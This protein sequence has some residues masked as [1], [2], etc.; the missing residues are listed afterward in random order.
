MIG[1][2]VAL[3]Q[4]NREKRKKSLSDERRA[5]KWR[6]G[7]ADVTS[8]AKP[9]AQEKEEEGEGELES[10]DTLIFAVR[11]DGF[12]FSFYSLHVTDHLTQAVVTGT[13]GT[14]THKDT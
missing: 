4:C 11:V 10:D 13:P 8:E 7:G 1:E 14:R 6:G 9:D 3:Q 2:A 5:K 12:H